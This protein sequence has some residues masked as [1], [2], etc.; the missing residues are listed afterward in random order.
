MLIRLNQLFFG[1]W[2]RSFGQREFKYTLTDKRGAPAIPEVL[3]EGCEV[4]LP[5]LQPRYLCQ[6]FVDGTFLGIKG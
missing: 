1:Q 6:V 3:L 4:L 2:E 5:A